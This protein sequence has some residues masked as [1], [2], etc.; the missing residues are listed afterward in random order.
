MRFQGQVVWITGATSGI[1]EALAY[2]FSREGAKVVLS[3]RR[4]AELERVQR[5]CAGG[6][7]SVMTLPLDLTEF[8]SLPEK[9]RQ[10]EARFGRVDILVNNGGVSQRSLAKD[11][12]FAVEQAIMNTNYFGTVALTKAVLPGMLARQAGQLVIISSLVGYLD[13]P[14]RSAYSASKHALHGYFDS[15]RAEIWRQN[16]GVTMVCP[17][18]VKTEVSLNAL[19]GD[20]RKHAHMD[21]TQAN[22][23]S[24]EKC[25]AQILHAVARGKDEVLIGGK[26]VLAVYLKRFLPWLY[27]RVVRRLKFG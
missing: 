14:L 3:G 18:Y 10:V 23:I 13:T 17:G 27:A 20:G 24:A 15:L 21:E 6:T 16:V 7:G 25:A 19:T 22:G 9:A 11:T 2:A 26:E 4:V 12:D 1:G 8:A 5:N